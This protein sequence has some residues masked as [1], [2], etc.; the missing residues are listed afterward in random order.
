MSDKDLGRA[1]APASMMD[2]I[3]AL[4]G[5]KDH[6]LGKDMTGIQPLTLVSAKMV[7][8]HLAKCSDRQ[9]VLDGTVQAA[10][11]TAPAPRPPQ[12]EVLPQL[13]AFT[14]IP[15]GFYATPCP[16]GSNDL[17]FWRVTKGKEG[18]KWAESS[19]VKRV[20]GGGSGTEIR[21]E[22][23]GNIQQRRAL[24]AI[25][26]V[27][28]DASKKAF[29]DAIDRCSDCGRMLTDDVSRSFGKGPTCRNKKG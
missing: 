9:S 13:S 29:A 2:E 10:T 17:D 22:E 11:R 24:V 23:L 15:E 20:L 4:A 7:L 28:T 27:G 26:E 3:R 5:R 14:D 1:M 8:A 21:T 19:F 25:R 6:R 12:G 18:T 16:T